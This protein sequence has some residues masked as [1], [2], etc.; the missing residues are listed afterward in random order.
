MLVRIAFIIALLLGTLTQSVAQQQVP[1]P[2]RTQTVA[3]EPSPWFFGGSFGLSFGTITR[4]AA[5]PI[6]GYQVTDDFSAGLRITYEYI[7]DNRFAE[8]YNFNNYGGG[9]FGRYR[10]IPQAYAHAEFAYNSY[11]FGISDTETNREWVPFLFLGGGYIQS[12]GGNTNLFVEILFD[13]IQDPNSPF[14]NWQPF[15]QMGVTTG[16]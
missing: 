2:A 13:V 5:W 6:V 7:R 8:P 3:E 10:F 14:A 11:G 16:F 15:I 12:L 1:A 4:I 9:L